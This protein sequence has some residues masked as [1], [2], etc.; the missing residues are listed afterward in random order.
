MVSFQKVSE[1]REDWGLCEVLSRVTP[2][3]VVFRGLW[4]ASRVKVTLKLKKS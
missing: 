1:Q 2:M 4:S 3:H